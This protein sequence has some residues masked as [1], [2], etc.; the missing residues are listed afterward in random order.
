MAQRW[1]LAIIVAGAAVTSTRAGQQRQTLAP[2]ELK[3]SDAPPP[4]VWSTPELP[5]HPLKVES[6]E[7]RRL[8]VDVVAKG[9]QQPWSMAFLPDGAILVTERTGNVRIVRDGELSAPVA[10][11]PRVRTGGDRGREG[12]VDV[13]LQ[14]RFAENHWVYRTYHK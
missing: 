4:I 5:S 13:V 12:L 3:N 1:A 11:V 7:E 14:R 6:A 10:G 9:L 8:R 2:H